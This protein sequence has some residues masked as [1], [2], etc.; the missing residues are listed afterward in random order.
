[1]IIQRSGRKSA[2]FLYVFARVCSYEQKMNS[3]SITS[4]AVHLEYVI[5][6]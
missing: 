2:P 4:H 5:L 6:L 3:M 1:M